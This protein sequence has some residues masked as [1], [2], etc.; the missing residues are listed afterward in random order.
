MEVC[1]YYVIVYKQLLKLKYNNRYIIVDNWRVMG[2]HLG[3]Y[4]KKTVK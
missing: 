2:Q 4:S 1:L 3:V